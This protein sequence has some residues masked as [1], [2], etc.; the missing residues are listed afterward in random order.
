M[1]FLNHDGELDGRC[2]TRRYG[3]EAAMVLSALDCILNGRKGIYG[4]SELTTGKRFYDLLEETGARDREGLYQRLGEAAFRERLWNPNVE[5]ANAFARRIAGR[6]GGDRPVIT[7]APFSAPDWSQPEYLAFW[8]SLIRTRLEAAYFHRGWQYSNGCSFEFAVAVDGGLAT[9][10]H[11]G[12]TLELDEGIALVRT[13]V[14]EIEGM[15]LTPIGLRS[16]LER[17]TRLA[18]RRGAR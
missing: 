7:P 14:A 1:R 17:L 2:F 13:A 12:R 16:N 15:G 9:H 3:D 4:S 18:V 5:A 8:E 11:Q 10:D 6:F